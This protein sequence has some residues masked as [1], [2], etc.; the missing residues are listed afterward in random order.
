MKSE[1]L[2]V[3]LSTWY[4][5]PKRN[6]DFFDRIHSRPLKIVARRRIFMPEAK[7]LYFETVI[8]WREPI[9][10]SRCLSTCNALEAALVP[11]SSNKRRR[12]TNP[13]EVL[14]DLYGLDIVGKIM[15]LVPRRKAFEKGSFS[16][17]SHHSFCRKSI[18]SSRT[19]SSVEEAKEVRSCRQAREL[20]RT[21][22]AKER[23][24]YRVVCTIDLYPL[25]VSFN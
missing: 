21:V 3:D 17:K 8:S 13:L 18:T 20:R 1:I 7:P 24:G 5:M 25:L 19:C 12:C 16:L 4:S 2:A 15:R 10:T 14:T 6:P 9:S 23:N 22:N 11:V